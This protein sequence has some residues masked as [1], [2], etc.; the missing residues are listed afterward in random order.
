MEIL[1]WQARNSRGITLEKLA[2][3]T[4]IGKST[5]SDY[6]NARTDPRMSA[7]EKIAE[8]LNMKIEDLYNSKYK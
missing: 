3:L 6:E 2:S 8:A 5:L 7:M 1:I 4:G